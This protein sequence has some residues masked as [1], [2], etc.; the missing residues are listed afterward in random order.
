MYGTMLRYK[1]GEGTGGR[2]EGKGEEPH[3]FTLPSVAFPEGRD[4]K[5][6]KKTR[7]QR[8]VSKKKRSRFAS[9]EAIPRGKRVESCYPFPWGRAGK[10][11]E[12]LVLFFTQRDSAESG[13]GPRKMFTE[14]RREQGRV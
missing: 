9:N 10:S 4:G 3:I 6:K 12:R 14:S 5:K 2:E 13:E 11:A 7:F 1:S 8:R